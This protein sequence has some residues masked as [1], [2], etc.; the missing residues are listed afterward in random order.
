[1]KTLGKRTATTLTTVAVAALLLS[2]CSGAAE[3]ASTSGA[4]SGS[5]N[6]S[7]GAVELE[8][9]TWLPTQVQWPEIVSAFEEENPGIT[10][11]FTR[12]ED[13]DA[14]RTNLDNEILA[15]ETPDI[16]GIQAGASFNDYAEYALPAEE[17]A[18]EWIDQIREEPLKETT[19]ADGELAAVPILTAGMQ[20]YL[21]N[22]TLFEANG[23]ELP[24]NYEDLK[25]V[26]AKATEAG[27][28]PFA[29][30]ASDAWHDSD[31]FVWLS[32]QY[33][34]GG[35]VYKAAEGEIPWDSPSLVEAATAWQSLFS[36]GIFQ[37][38]ALTT[39]T[40]PAARDDYFLAGKALAFPT[41][42]W[43]VGMALVGPDQEQPGSAIENDEVGMAVFPQI[44]PNEGGATSGVDFALALSADIDDSKLDAA[45]KFVEF[46]AVGNGQQMWVDMLQGFP[47]AKD[48]EI[49]VADSEPEIAVESLK[50]VSDAL[51]DSKYPRKL[52]VPGWDSLENDLGI[53]LQNIAGGAD[54]K[55]ELATLNR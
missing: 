8:F 48:I 2:A 45:S 19:T 54:P 12:E 7:D 46:M 5:G 3:D 38:G 34:E 41:G 27:L 30:G 49:Q 47:V 21:Y 35:D 28:T 43:H 40:Y 50:T 4:T 1:M 55:S 53:V 32:N 17:Y 24:T 13:Y 51:A 9:H 18:S 39:T 11:N 42:S 52:I 10:I 6:A 26:A 23:L 31:F 37:Q 15:G 20:F 25:A 22:K 29:M 36:D 16:Y 33:G 14:F 44:G